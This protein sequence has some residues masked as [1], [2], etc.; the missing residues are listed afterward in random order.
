MAC[1]GVANAGVLAAAAG[2]VS[3]DG[4]PSRC[5]AIIV[6]GVLEEGYGGSFWMS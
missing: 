1:C 4:E 2:G 3:Q 5:S 6:V